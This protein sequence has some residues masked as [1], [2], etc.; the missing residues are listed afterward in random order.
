MPIMNTALLII[1]SDLV[2]LVLA[3]GTSLVGIGIKWG[4]INAE[5]A[6][7]KESLAEIKGMFVLRLRD[8]D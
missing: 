6:A 5:L 7:V 2:T 1:V 3:I 8:R 4:R